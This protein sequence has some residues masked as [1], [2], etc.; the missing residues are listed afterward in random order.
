[1]LELLVCRCQFYCLVAEMTLSLGGLGCICS[2]NDKS[3][4][5]TFFVPGRGHFGL[6]AEHCS[7][8]SHMFYRAGK[9]APAFGFF[10]KIS[11]EG[12]HLLFGVK[13]TNVPANQLLSGVVA[14]HR[15]PGRIKEANGSSQVDHDNPISNLFRD[16]C[17]LLQYLLDLLIS[18]NYII[19]WANP[20]KTNATSP[21]I[22]AEDLLVS[23]RFHHNTRILPPSLIGN[24]NIIAIYR[25]KVKILIVDKR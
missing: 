12:F 11:H 6:R 20:E 8:L 1:M 3:D 14:M 21:L 23:M 10:N 5:F 15:D 9:L 13:F 4:G 24:E 17:Y 19:H 7:T 22:P 16:Y 18:S 2:K 25:P